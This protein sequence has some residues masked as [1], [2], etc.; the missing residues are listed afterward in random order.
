MYVINVFA[1]MVAAEGIYPR[2]ANTP[3]Y[4]H[5][6]NS[7]QVSRYQNWKVYLKINFIFSCVAW[8]LEIAEPWVKFK[9]NGDKSYTFFILEVYE[10][11]VYLAGYISLLHLK[12]DLLT[13]LVSQG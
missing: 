8:F 13:E 1:Q 12:T 4:P 2:Q 11:G 10:R 3:S 9:I 5:F 7:F 6:L